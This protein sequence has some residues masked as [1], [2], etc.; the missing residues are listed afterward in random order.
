MKITVKIKNYEH[1]G[2][3]YGKLWGGSMGFYPFVVVSE[4]KDLELS[5]CPTSDFD[6]TEG[7][8]YHTNIQ[9]ITKEGAFI[10]IY[11]T[12]SKIVGFIPD[13]VIKRM[14]ECE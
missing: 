8:L 4:D 2:F 6:T 5:E 1:R 10:R 9:G 11:G 3:V 14:E 12:E 7:L 13:E